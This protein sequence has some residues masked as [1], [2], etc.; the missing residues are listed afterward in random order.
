MTQ[1]QR[2]TEGCGGRYKHVNTHSV[3][4]ITHRQLWRAGEREA[5]TGALRDPIP[6]GEECTREEVQQ[7]GPRS[8]RP[9]PA[10]TI[11][12]AILDPEAAAHQQR[13][14]DSC[15]LCADSSL[16]KAITS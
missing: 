7:A 15:T 1:I 11:P 13:Q 6:S 12:S 4:K 10:P 9:H 5:P 14:W 2:L 8:S 3:L 16:M